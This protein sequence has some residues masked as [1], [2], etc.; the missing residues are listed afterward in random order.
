MAITPRQL[1]ARGDGIGSSDAAAILG[2]SPWKNAADVRLEKLGLV[3]PQPASEL[4]EIGT[5]LEDGIAR[6]AEKRLGC[7]LVKPTATYRLEGTPLYANLDRQVE[8][9]ARG[10]PLAECKDTGLDDA[11][12]EPGTDQVPPYVLCQ[13]SHQMLCADAPEAHIARLGRGFNRGLFMFLVERTDEVKRLMD[14]MAKLLPKWWAMYV[15]DQAPL[16]DDYKPPHLDMLKRIRREPRT[17]VQLDAAQVLA[18]RRAEEEA[19][20]ADTARDEA[21]ARVLASLGE[22]EGGECEHGAL[23]YLEQSRKEFVVKASTFRVARWK[24]AK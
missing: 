21:K 11:W 2:F 6:I 1:E 4:A 8:R 20:R 3:D 18:W 22:A 16:P 19:K 12:G 14:L 5:D 13:V 10:Q 15:V 17:V 24:P 23:S 9:A 7:R